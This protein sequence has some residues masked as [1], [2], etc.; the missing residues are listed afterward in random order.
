MT[1]GSPPTTC[2]STCPLLTF[3]WVSIVSQ[4]SSSWE[5]VSG[6]MELFSATFVNSWLSSPSA[7]VFSQ[8]L[9]WLLKSTRYRFLVYLTF[10]YR[11]FD[12]VLTISS[13]QAI[14]T[15]LATKLKGYQLLKVFLLIWF[16]KILNVLFIW[17]ELCDIWNALFSGSLVVSILPAYMSELLEM[18]HDTYVC[19]IVWPDGAQ[20][21]SYYDFW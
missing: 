4:A 14:V 5:M 1:W 21:R 3:W 11:W 12:W 9:A 6:I 18:S 20:G 13:L 8:F 16:G 15:P 2:W 17:V 10:S 19:I 7:W